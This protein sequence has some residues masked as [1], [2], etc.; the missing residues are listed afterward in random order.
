MNTDLH[1]FE[2]LFFESGGILDALKVLTIFTAVPLITMTGVGILFSLFQTVFQLQEAS[3][4]LF[5]KLLAFGSLLYFAR[6]L[7]FNFITEYLLLLMTLV[8]E[9]AHGT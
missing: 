1:T 6:F 4:T 2:F 9:I 8:K 3:L 7:I 5:A